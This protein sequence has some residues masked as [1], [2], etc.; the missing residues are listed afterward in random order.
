MKTICFISL[1]FLGIYS[2][3]YTG[4]ISDSGVQV[5]KVGTDQ[6]YFTHNGKPLLSF[7]GGSDFIFYAETDAFDYKRWA[8]W[9]EE[10][11]INHIRAYPP[12]SWKHIEKFA[13]ENGGSLDNLL[14]PYKETFPGSRQFDLTEFDEDYWKRFRKQCEY[15]ESRGIIIHLLMWNG[16]QLR[17]NGLDWQGHFFNPEN[18][19]NN[20]TNH[21]GGDLKNRFKLYHS[22]SD[23]KTNLFNAQKAWF[24]KLIEETH[25]LDNVY[26][27]LVHEIAEH[28]GEWSKTKQWI[29]EIAQ[30][31]RSKWAEL[32]PNKPIVLGMDAGGLDRGVQKRG[33]T[34]PRDGSQVDWIFTRPYFDVVIWGKVHYV[35]DALKWRKK[36]KKPYIGQESWDDNG[37][38]YSYRVPDQRVHI[39][40]Y[41][42]K[43]MMAKCQQMDLYYKPRDKA[44]NPPGYPHNYEPNGWS[45]FEEDAK[46]LRQFWNR[47]V[48]YP[49]LYFDGWIEDG[50]GSHKYVLSS[51][52][53]AVAY[54]SSA[55]YKENVN[56]NA[57]DL[58]LRGLSLI[59]GSYKAEIINPAIG[60]V[61]TCTVLAK[62]GAVDLSLLSFIDDIAVH[63]YR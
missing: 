51:R 55:T 44:N 29:E 10:H 12:L 38:K 7:G 56:Y 6:V 43:F 28:C 53:E 47:L 50:P 48:D 9:A 5:A 30:A 52:V 4:E 3:M 2:Q 45:L 63:I 25:G 49:N 31:V 11:G 57:Q 8:G 40:K 14:F 41:M 1:L 36:Y 61:E 32:E 35:E 24:S 33:P 15:L 34:I 39:R 59:D 37:I 19:V 27:D 46:V 23:D 58:K 42:W 21:L 22:V 54:C 20:F 16:W 18:N 17:D 26:F 60:I 62:A 13:K